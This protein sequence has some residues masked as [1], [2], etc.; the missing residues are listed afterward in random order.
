MLSSYTKQNTL[1]VSSNLQT[2]EKS[3]GRI[4][5]IY[6]ILN[7]LLRICLICFVFFLKKISVSSFTIRMGKTGLTNSNNSKSAEVAAPIFA[8]L[9]FH[10]YPYKIIFPRN[11]DLFLKN[12]KINTFPSLALPS[13]LYHTNHHQRSFYCPIYVNTKKDL[14]ISLKSFLFMGG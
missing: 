9:K 11:H 13:S 12:L 2:K 10:L 3:G 1:L 4:L 6:L 14:R 5:K 8:Y 7:W